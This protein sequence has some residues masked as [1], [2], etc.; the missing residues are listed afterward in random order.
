[1]GEGCQ[2]MGERGER[3]EAALPMK[4]GLSGVGV[5]DGRGDY[6]WR[7]ELSTGEEGIGH[8]REQRGA[9]ES[10]SS[11]DDCSVGREIEEPIDLGGL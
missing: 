3:R 11:N 9:L 8:R 10:K 7:G 6:P 4:E 2:G 1:M 5:G